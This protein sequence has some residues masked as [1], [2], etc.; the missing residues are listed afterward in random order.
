N[1]PINYIDSTG[2]DRDLSAKDMDEYRANMKWAASTNGGKLF[3]TLTYTVLLA[4]IDTYKDS[5]DLIA[6]KDIL[7]QEK[8]SRGILITCML[9]PE[10]VDKLLKSGAKV[11]VKGTGKTV[12]K[13]Q[14]LLD[15]HYAKHASEF[16]KIT[17]GQYLKSAQNLVNQKPG[18]NILTK[19]RSN[20]DVLFYNKANN[21]F[22]IKASDGTIRTY[23]KPSDGI[24]YFYRQK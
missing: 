17:K 1:G 15:S 11:A 23:F 8:T 5:A 19:T 21:E 10:A 12:F 3:T 14:E 2:H 20:G 9:T 7:T 22:A 13:T 6:G 16:G 18:G 24:D 4:P